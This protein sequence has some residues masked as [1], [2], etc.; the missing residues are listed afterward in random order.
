[1]KTIST[2]NPPKTKLEVVSLKSA[3]ELLYYIR[4]Y[5]G[6]LEVGE[7]VLSVC[8]GGE[9]IGLGSLERGEVEMLVERC[10]RRLGKSG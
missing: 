9:D 3:A 10:R 7:R 8:G 6:S 5:V 2:L 4:D 1:L